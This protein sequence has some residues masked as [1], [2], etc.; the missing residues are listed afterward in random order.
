MKTFVASIGALLLGLF[1]AQ[2]GADYEASYEHQ[3]LREAAIL[4]LNKGDLV[5]FDALLKAGLEINKPLDAESKDTALHMLVEKNKPDMIRQLLQRGADPMVRNLWDIR[6]ID[7]LN[8]SRRTDIGAVVAALKRDVTQHD[9]KQLMDIPVPVWRE[10]LGPPALPDSPLAPPTNDG[11]SDILIPFVSINGND[12]APEMAPVLNVH[13]PHWKPG[14]CAVE[15]S[16]TKKATHSSSYW[17]KQTHE[18]GR[19]VQINIQTCKNVTGRGSE[20][21]IKHMSADVTTM[22]EFQVRQATGP[23]M[24]GGGQRGYVVPVAGYWVKTGVQGW[25]E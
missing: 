23:S 19:L 16:D 17:D 18:H 15:V 14:S 24:S 11:A 2:A 7:E 12:P 25:D 21:L 4:A 20:A 3:Y 13:Y 10:V 5:L 22:Y 1:Q 9:K 8:H 6:P